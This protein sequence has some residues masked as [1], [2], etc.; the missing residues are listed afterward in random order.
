MAFAHATKDALRILLT[1]P[2]IDT[3]VFIEEWRHAEPP[4]KEESWKIAERLLKKHKLLFQIARATVNQDL[5]RSFFYKNN[6]RHR[7]VYRPVVTQFLAGLIVV[8]I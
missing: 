5:F 7:G 1:F 3:R 2:K 6:P 4:D 8:C